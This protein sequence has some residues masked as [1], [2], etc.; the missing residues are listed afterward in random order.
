MT[1]GSMT[2]A[3]S[4]YKTREQTQLADAKQELTRRGRPLEVGRIIA[5]LLFAFW[6]GL[7]NAPY[8]R[9]LWDPRTAPP[10]RR[11]SP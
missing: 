8:E 6:T 4:L 1:A 3:S 11:S 7:L 2:R 9:Q 10:H 5:E